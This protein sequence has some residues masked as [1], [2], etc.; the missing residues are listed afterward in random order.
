MLK[1]PRQRSLPDKDHLVET[2]G[3]DR[4]DEAFSVRIHVWCP[5]RRENNVD[6]NA[7]R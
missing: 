6:S 3:L 1:H 7:V 5:I 4:T 2:L